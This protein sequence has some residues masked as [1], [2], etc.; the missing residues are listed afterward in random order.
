M[1]KTKLHKLEYDF[2]MA[3]LLIDEHCSSTKAQI[4]LYAEQMMKEIH[5]KRLDLIGQVDTYQNDLVRNLE[6][7]INRP[8]MEKTLAQSL[9]IL[10]GET[11]IDFVEQQLRTLQAEDDQ[12]RKDMFNNRLI[13]FESIYTATPNRN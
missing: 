8:R 7:R 12:L 6:L 5:E 1:L 2:K 10:C 9:D 13:E 3:P 4:D 11:T